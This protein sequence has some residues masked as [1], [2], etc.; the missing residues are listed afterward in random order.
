MTLDRERNMH[1]A[2]RKDLKQLVEIYALRTRRLSEVVADLGAYV[3]AEKQIDE[4][5]TE[6]KKQPPSGRGWRGSFCIHRPAT[7]GVIQAVAVNQSHLFF[8]TEI[9]CQTAHGLP[10]FIPRQPETWVATETLVRSNSPVF[11]K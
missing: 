2:R 9:L 6:I 11:S 8:L 7:R 4:I 10:G 5:I 1:P 3:T